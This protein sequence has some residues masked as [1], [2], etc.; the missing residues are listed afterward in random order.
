MK[1]IFLFFTVSCNV[2][3]SQNKLSLDR[4][5]KIKY[6]KNKKLFH[7]DN[8]ENHYYYND[9]EILKGENIKFSDF[10]LDT[11]SKFDLLNPLKIKLWYKNYSTLLVL[12]NYFNVI[13]RINFND[14]FYSSE[15]SHVSSSNENMVW[16]FDELSMK[17]K[18]F[19][20]IKNNFLDGV[21]FQLYEDVIDLKSDFNYLWILTKNYLYKLNYN[22]SEIYKL[23]N[24]NFNKINF[25]KKNIILSNDSDLIYLDDNEKKFTDI[26]N[27]KLFIKDFFVM[28]ETL[29][30]YNEDYLN[31][32]LIINK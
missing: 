7:I 8:L 10:S 16:V 32:Y 20:F 15:I 2:F 18:K 27:L 19:D 9:F 3:F 23:K 14:I 31:K 24:E 12:D 5:E 6:E 17:I 22:A 25:Y 29:Y 11:I 30:I 28:N 4:I 26:F 13:K 21:E 1:F